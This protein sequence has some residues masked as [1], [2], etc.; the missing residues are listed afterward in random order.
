MAYDP[1]ENTPSNLI[2]EQYFNSSAQTYPIPDHLEPELKY[3]V[4]SDASCFL[5]IL[6]TLKNSPDVISS[7]DFNTIPNG[8]ALLSVG[9]DTVSE[10]GTPT[11]KIA[12]AG[13]QYR[14]R[15]NLPDR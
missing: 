14:V 11:R 2:I 3:L 4:T 12:K 9:L 7:P 8:Y 5:E 10:D 6:E 13:Y 15:G 1:K